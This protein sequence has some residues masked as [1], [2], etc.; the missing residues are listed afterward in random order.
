MFTFLNVNKLMDTDIQK[1]FWSN[2]SGTLEHTELLTYLLNHSKL[3][4]R[5]LV[6]TLFD[7]KNAFGKVHHNVISSVLEKHHTP[8]H[9]IDLIKRMYSDYYISVLTKD[10]I[11]VKR[12]VLQGD[13]LS[14]LLFNL[15]INT[16]VASIKT[17]Q[18]KC[19]GYVYDI[20]LSPRY[21][22]QFADDTAIVTALQEDNQLLCNV[23]TKWTIW[24]DMII[25]VDK[26]HTFG[27]KK[28]ATAS[29]QYEPV[30][31]VNAER[32]PPIETNESFMYRGKIFNFSNCLDEIKTVQSYITTIDKLPLKNVNK[33]VIIQCYMYSKLRWKLS[34]YNLG[35][36]W[37]VQN[38]DNVISKYVRKWCQL[39]VS[40]N[41]Q[42][43]EFDVKH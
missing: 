17:D 38:L 41:V 13:C 30:I 16:L 8:E 26:C 33:L 11:K 4:Q 5:Q 42:H 23:F 27:I 20:N 31:L 19:L 34:I 14:P 40:T 37:V 39:P 21:W 35:E 43:L 9:V 6:I 32:V 12:G 15:C 7:L 36:T 1:G 25:R 2:L 29:I 18:I 28:S 24:A 3:K 10:Y 22:F